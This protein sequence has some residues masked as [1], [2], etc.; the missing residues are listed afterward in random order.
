M[1]MI[2]ILASAVLVTGV[3][4]VSKRAPLRVI[5]FVMAGLLLLY[6]VWLGAMIFLVGQNPPR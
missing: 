5:G 4:L 2:L 6:L 3:L 1:P